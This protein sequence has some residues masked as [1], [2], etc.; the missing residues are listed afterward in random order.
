MKE[1]L[2]YFLILISTFAG[3][4]S[5]E[6]EPDGKVKI[7]PYEQ[8]Q[9][10]DL[11]VLG[12]DIVEFHKRIES[13]LGFL[14]QRKQIQDNLYSQ[15]IPAYEDQIP[16]SRNRYMLDLRFVLKVSGAGATNSPLKLESVVFW[17]RKSLISKMRPQYEEIS[18][19]KNDKITNEGPN[20]IELVVRKKTDSGTKETVYNVATIREPAQ[21]IKLVRIYRTNLL[22]I[23]RRIDKYVQG[24]IKTAAEDVETTLR[25]VENGGPYQENPKE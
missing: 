24:S 13:R 23:I 25:E 22:E 11:E 7:L 6:F 1:K 18:I 15:F 3:I 9:I 10:K 5:Q 16:Q 8:G 21:R 14:N 2:F 19:L 17:S 20:S 4:S 12:K